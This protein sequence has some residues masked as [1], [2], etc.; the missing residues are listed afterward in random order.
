VV[1]KVR[2]AAWERIVALPYPVKKSFTSGVSWLYEDGMRY[3]RKVFEAAKK[4][5]LPLQRG[6]GRTGD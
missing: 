1:K 4:A 5:A 3:L 6:R 2:K